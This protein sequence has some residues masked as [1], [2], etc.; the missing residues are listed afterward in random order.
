[1]CVFILFSGKDGAATEASS[2][3]LAK[4]TGAD[5]VSASKEKN[6]TEALE[7]VRHRNLGYVNP[8]ILLELLTPCNSG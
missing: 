4:A 2:P 3:P 6:A 1:M 5:D 8:F 7:G